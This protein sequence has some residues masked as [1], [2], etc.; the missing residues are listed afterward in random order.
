MMGHRASSFR[1]YDA[2]QGPPMTAVIIKIDIGAIGDTLYNMCPLKTQILTCILT[3]IFLIFYF[4]FP[5]G[6]IFPSINIYYVESEELTLCIRFGDI[7]GFQWLWI[8]V[9]R[10]SMTMTGLN[11]LKF[12]KPGFVI[13]TITFCVFLILKGFICE[14]LLSCYWTTSLHFCSL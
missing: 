4:Y 8:S 3:L 11:F 13:L 7:Y 12:Q 10:M 6:D 9:P 1:I 14:R 2:L 5:L